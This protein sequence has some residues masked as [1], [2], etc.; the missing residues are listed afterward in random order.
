[1]M[2]CHRLSIWTCV[3]L[4]CPSGAAFAAGGT[5]FID[6]PPE[7]A[8]T[9]SL[10]PTLWMFPS[11]PGGRARQSVLF[12]G[13]DF[14]AANGLF[15]STDNGIGWNLS[16]RNDLQAGLRLWTAVVWRAPTRSARGWRRAPS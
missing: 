6:P 10:G 15:A 7:Q 2:L 11:Y 1:M 8:Y 13:I 3:L 5:I 14:Y 12:P 9:L 16:T 4:L